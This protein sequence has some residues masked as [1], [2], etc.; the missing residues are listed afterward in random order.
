MHYLQAT[1]F[2]RELEQNKAKRLFH[3]GAGSAGSVFMTVA[4]LEYFADFSL[5]PNEK[6]GARSPHWRDFR[7]VGRG[8]RVDNFNRRAW[9]QFSLRYSLFE[10]VCQDTGSILVL[11]VVQAQIYVE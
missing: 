6:I 8:C 1:Q 4:A 2:L 9:L 5:R 11:A 10:I 7:V 3:G